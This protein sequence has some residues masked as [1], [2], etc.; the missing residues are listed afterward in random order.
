M[1]L[2]LHSVLYTPEPENVQGKK[3]QN[4]QMKESTLKFNFKTSWNNK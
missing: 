4:T 1:W 2:F 3:N